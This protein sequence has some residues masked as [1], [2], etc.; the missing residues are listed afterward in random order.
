MEASHWVLGRTWG[1][2][3]LKGEVWVSDSSWLRS[4]IYSTF[5]LLGTIPWGQS[6]LPVLPSPCQEE[7]G[8]GCLGAHLR[9]E[10]PSG[11]QEK[12]AHPPFPSP[13][14]PQN[15]ANCSFSCLG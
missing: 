10:K 13:S 9:S 4:L 8:D 7:E 6:P 1:L 11:T 14:L 3:Y 2:S 12:R 5:T 15:P